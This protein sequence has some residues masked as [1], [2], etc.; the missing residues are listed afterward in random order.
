MSESWNE[1]KQE[2]SINNLTMQPLGGIKNQQSWELFVMH[3]VSQMAP[4]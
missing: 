1:E 3:P 4:P 2:E